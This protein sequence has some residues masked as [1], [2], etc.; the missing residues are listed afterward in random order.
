M[1]LPAFLHGAVDAFKR[2]GDIGNGCW[3]VLLRCE[4]RV[5]RR[6]A[7]LAVSESDGIRKD[8]MLEGAAPRS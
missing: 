4:M 2:E 6:R 8:Q 7:V 1:S 5:A 3:L